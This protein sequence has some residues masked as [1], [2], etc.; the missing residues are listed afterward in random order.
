MNHFLPLLRVAIVGPCAAGKSTLVAKLRAAG[1]KVHHV[2]QEHSYVANMWQRLTN[3]DVLI[4]L[5]V[6][7][8]TAKNRRP[9]IDWGPERLVEQSHR[10]RHARQ[11]CHLYLNTSTLNAAQVYEQVSHFLSQWPVLAVKEA[12]H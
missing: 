8:P 7:Y 4:Y 9:N 5:D 10:L 6:D 1:Y 2:A 3:P 11:H 12:I